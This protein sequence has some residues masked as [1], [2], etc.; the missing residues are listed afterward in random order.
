MCAWLGTEDGAVQNMHGTLSVCV[1][2]CVCVCVRVCVL[3][4]ASLFCQKKKKGLL[5]KNLM[6]ERMNEPVRT[7]V[8]LL[9]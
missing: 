5:V 1:C 3:V 8:L 4:L 9:T 2:V 6:M 7:N